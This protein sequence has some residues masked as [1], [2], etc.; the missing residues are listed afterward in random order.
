[1]TARAMLLAGIVAVVACEGFAPSARFYDPT[2][3][4]PTCPFRPWMN[5]GSRWSDAQAQAHQDRS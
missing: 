1:M 2:R 3:G 4:T 5:G